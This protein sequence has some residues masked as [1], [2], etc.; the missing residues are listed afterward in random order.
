MSPLEA[1]QWLDQTQKLKEHR[2]RAALADAV[3]D[4]EHLV[5]EVVVLCRESR[6]V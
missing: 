6:L 4:R 5:Q 1:K 3:L 2:L